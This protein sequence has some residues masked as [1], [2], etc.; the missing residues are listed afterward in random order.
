[1]WVESFLYLTI[2]HKFQLNRRNKR[3]ED[4]QKQVELITKYFNR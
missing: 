1:M 3:G 4:N 2:I